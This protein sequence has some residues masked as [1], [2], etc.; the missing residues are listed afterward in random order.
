ME[1]FFSRIKILGSGTTKVTAYQD[2]N[3][4][5]SPAIPVINYLSVIKASQYIS[6]GEIEDHSVG[7]F[8]FALDA[9]SSSGLTLNL[10]IG[11][12]LKLQLKM[13]LSMYMDNN[14]VTISAIQK[15][16]R[17]FEPAES[18][19]KTSQSDMVIYSQILHPV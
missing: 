3:D 6:F 13:D 9:N 18:I 5:Y 2:G 16:D 8:P 1:G 12:L 15:G 10:N 11:F 17:R 4:I 7:D 14:I 19:V